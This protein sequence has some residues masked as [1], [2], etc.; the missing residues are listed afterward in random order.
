LTGG[1]G[2]ARASLILARW[3]ENIQLMLAPLAFR[4]C[5][6][7]AICWIDEGPD[8]AGRVIDLPVDN[9]TRRR[10]LRLTKNATQRS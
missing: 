7:E 9:A 4:R 8:L 10:R 1:F 3:V 6:Q 5:S 2:L